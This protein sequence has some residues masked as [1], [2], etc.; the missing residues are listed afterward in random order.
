[1]DPW[2]SAVLLCCSQIILCWYCHQL[3]NEKGY[4]HSLF[5]VCGIIP[6]VSLVALMLLL[7]LPER[8][9]VQQS[10]YFSRQRPRP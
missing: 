4:S 3:A 6:I 9:P 10:L 2:F 8:G 1:M 5:A 7:V